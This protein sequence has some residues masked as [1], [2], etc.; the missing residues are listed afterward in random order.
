MEKTVTDRLIKFQIL[1]F[2]QC[3]NEEQFDCGA[4]RRSAHFAPAFIN[5]PRERIEPSYIVE[6]QIINSLENSQNTISIMFNDQGLSAH[7]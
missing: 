2:A 3:F 6:S 7:L 4:T 5:M 1:Y